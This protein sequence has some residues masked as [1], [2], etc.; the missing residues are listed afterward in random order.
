M[1][2]EEIRDRFAALT[3]AHVAAACLR[4]Q[5]P[6][7]CAPAA[8]T[9][10]EPGTTLAGPAVPARHAGSLDIFLEAF[11]TRARPGAVLVVDNAGRTDEACVG[12][13]VVLEAHAAGLAGVLIWGLHRD[14]ADIRAIGLP[15]F[16]LGALPTGPLRLDPRPD[17]ALEWATVGEHRVSGEDVVLADDDGALF[18]PAARTGDLLTLAEGI[19]DTERNQAARIGAGTTLRAQLDFAAYLARRQHT[20]AYTFRDHLRTRGAAIE[21]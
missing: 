7:R 15:L 18:V 10:L 13:L 21:E 17:H 6:V 4:A 20:P 1:D 9:P 14:T 3:T 19:R 16:S 11:E 8:L 2:S 5:L 12:D